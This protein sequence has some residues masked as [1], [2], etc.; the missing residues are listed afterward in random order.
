MKL[1]GKTIVLTGAAGG[2]GKALAHTLSEQSNRLILVGRNEAALHAVLRTLRKPEVHQIC[3]ADITQ[4]EDRE[5]LKA[6]CFS[7]P[8]GIDLLINNAGISQFSLIEEHN[9]NSIETI[10]GTNLLAPMLL[11]KLLLPLL[12]QA[13]EAMIVN[14]G[15]SFGSI[16]YPGFAGYSAS[17]FGLRG[18]N[19]ALRR[20]LANSTVKVSYV[21]P[22]A[23]K[24]AINS[25]AVV[26]MN[27]E[28]GNAMDEPQAVARMIVNALQRRAG[29]DIYI[30]WPE[31]L[32]V[33]INALFPRLVDRSLRKQ[34][35]TITQFSVQ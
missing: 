17:K 30:G 32:F 2:L 3:L 27:R 15:S 13:S 14:V 16:G 29:K 20:E 12:K 19:E 9:E 31:K 6:Q 26:A 25:D 21:A 1:T 5:K 33:R 35:V 34:L 10:L 22:R 4:P 23:T 8:G 28:L 7:L 24:T 11:C 18:F